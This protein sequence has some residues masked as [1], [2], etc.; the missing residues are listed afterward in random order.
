MA[1]ELIRLRQS[2]GTD[3]GGSYNSEW[4][5]LKVEGM[6][7]LLSHWV[8]RLPPNS[9]S[10]LTS[11]LLAKMGVTSGHLAGVCFAD[12]AAK[13][14]ECGQ[15]ELAERLL[16][17]EPRASAKIPL[18]MRMQKLVVISSIL[19]LKLILSIACILCTVQVFFTYLI[20]PIQQFWKMPKIIICHSSCHGGFVWMHCG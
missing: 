18:L 14:I 20:V 5:R 7:R 19:V 11:T 16:D 6:T 12:V 1:V 15:T 3:G 2:I 13:A 4:T 9:A 17:L 8:S 10:R